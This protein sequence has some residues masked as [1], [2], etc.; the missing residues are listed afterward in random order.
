[1][2]HVWLAHDDVL[3]RS[4]AVK[5]VLLPEG[6]TDEELTELRLRTMREARTAAR[7]NH[8]NVVRIYDVF[9]AEDR[10][11]IVMEYVPSRSLAQAVKE[12]GPMAPER[13]ARVGLA[14]VDALSAAHKAGVLHRDVKPGNVLLADDGRVMLTDFGLATFDEINAPLTQTGVVYG[15]PQFI[16]PERALDGTSSPAADMWSLGA[17]IYAAVEGRSP[18]S[19]SSSYATL[20]ALATTSPDPPRRAG[21][22]EPVLIGLLSRNPRN[23]ML[24]VEA[25]ALLARIATDAEA[26][27]RLIP[28]QRRGVERVGA[29]A[30]PVAAS[31][32]ATG[33]APKAIPE[34]VTELFA[35]PEP[36]GAAWPTVDTRDAWRWAPEPRRRRWLLPTIAAGAAVLIVGGAIGWYA[37]S[38]PAT[39]QVVSTPTPDQQNNGG[40]RPGPPPPLP[41]A[42]VSWLCRPTAPPNTKAVVPAKPPS[43]AVSLPSNWTWYADPSGFRLGVPADWRVAARDGTECFYESAYGPRVLGVNEWPVTT[44]N[45]ATALEGREND[46]FDADGLPH[47]VRVRLEQVPCKGA[48]GEWEYTYEG[49]AGPLHAIVWISL[50][51]AGRAYAITWATPEA[52]WAADQASYRRVIE[53]FTAG[54]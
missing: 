38:R 8:P 2:G 11:W 1:M 14:L 49:P 12:Y 4:V 53:A 25:R 28:R 20:A 48:C 3:G 9:F 45:P 50:G 7:L 51:P 26:P 29:H 24:P 52:D 5:E 27:G 46:L 44:T 41:P 54:G 36:I 17:T 33:D 6:L 42:N 39:P 23:R 21:S 22:L 13:A 19:R 43:G 30:A 18:Y 47:Y 32:M 35:V 31:E 15:S 37:V 40:V 10:P 34:P 16:A